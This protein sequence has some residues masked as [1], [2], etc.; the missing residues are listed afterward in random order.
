M[1]LIL[2]V[3][4]ALVISSCNG[5]TNSTSGNNARG[6]VWL[7]NSEK[8]NTP[9]NFDNSHESKDPVIQ[10]KDPNVERRESLI[11]WYKYSH[12]QYMIELEL[13]RG[14]PGISEYKIREFYER[15]LDYNRA[16]EKEC[17]SWS[18]LQISLETSN[19]DRLIVKL[20][21]QR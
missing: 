8:V 1:R 9:S 12:L 5:S 6:S 2:L 7:S 14:I 18:D 3:L 10:K 4:F 21:N 15:D 20:K 17:E 19:L 16:R 13:S 11:K